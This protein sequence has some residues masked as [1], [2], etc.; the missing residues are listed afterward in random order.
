M[1]KEKQQSYFPALGNDIKEA[2][3]AL[4][5][6]RKN[7]AEMVHIDPRY[8]ANIE[9]SG[10]FPSLPLFYELVKICKL[11]VED[12]FFPKTGNKDSEQRKRTNHKLR[13][14]PEKYLS[15]VE[16]TISE[17]IKLEEAESE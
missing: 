9:N 15:I 16:A 8:L 4:N 14:C 3:K 12:Y 13:L 17:A 1:S 6:S 5:L 11:P 2:R 10:S 7:L